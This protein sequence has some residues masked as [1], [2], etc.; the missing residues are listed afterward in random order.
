MGNIFQLSEAYLCTIIC[1]VQ[2]VPYSLAKPVHI[3]QN[4]WLG[5]KNGTPCR[6]SRKRNFTIDFIFMIQQN[7]I[8]KFIDIELCP[9]MTSLKSL[10]SFHASLNSGW[11][12]D[13]SVTYLT[14]SK[15]FVYICFAFRIKI[16]ILWPTDRNTDRPT[17][18]RTGGVIGKLNFQQVKLVT[19][20][21]PTGHNPSRAEVVLPL[22]NQYGLWP[23]WE[24]GGW[25]LRCL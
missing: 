6:R 8:T 23:F 15:P 17:N 9:V 19:F 2:D 21:L 13:R 4:S 24:I 20:W 12:V 3:K 25:E 18:G 1:F 11:L 5:N 7:F 14:L 16:R 22:K 10:K